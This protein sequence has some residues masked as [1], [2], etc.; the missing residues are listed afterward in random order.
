[1]STAFHP[2]SD[3]QTERV[4][5]TLEEVLRS[6]VA[7]DQSDWDK[8]LPL[9]EFAIN[10]SI[11]AATGT[12]PFLMDYGQNPLTPNMSALTSAE[13]AD[14]LFPFVG[15]WRDTVRTV[16]H[17]T[18]NAQHRYKQLFDR[19][20]ADKEFKVGQQVLLAS[21]NLKA[22]LSKSH[23]AERSFKL[24][25]KHIG[26]FPIINRVGK[27]AYKLDL[28]SASILKDIHPVFHVSLLREFMQSTKFKRSGGK[29]DIIAGETHHEVKGI[30]DRRMHYG[31]PQ[32]FVEFTDGSPGNWAFE[33][34]L[35]E[36]MP[37]AI[38]KLIADYQATLAPRKQ[39]RNERAQR[40]TRQ[41]PKRRRQ[42]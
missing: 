13:T 15:K 40:Q 20:A 25:T 18:N 2:R 3:G 38:N 42:A 23:E 28:S 10:N 24:M 31:Y 7:G 34:D 37:V 19:K 17:N 4:N 33:A 30:S 5:R 22:L 26:P 12:T 32:Y 14:Q 6:Y 9:A 29:T 35:R 8:H 16:K 39:A 27:V 41:Q 21:K 36:D 1:M 11:Q